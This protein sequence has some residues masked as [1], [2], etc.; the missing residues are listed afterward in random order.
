VQ[1]RAAPTA[2]TAAPSSG[3]TSASP[4][5]VAKRSYQPGSPC[6]PRS[7]SS[8]FLRNLSAAARHQVPEDVPDAQDLLPRAPLPS[9]TSLSSTARVRAHAPDAKLAISPPG[10]HRRHA[11]LPL[12]GVMIDFNLPQLV[13][14]TQVSSRFSPALPLFVLVTLA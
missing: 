2:P 11:F 4:F 14:K 8:A 10:H 9:S 5:V 13:R 1:P 6:C 3:S 7:P 12:H